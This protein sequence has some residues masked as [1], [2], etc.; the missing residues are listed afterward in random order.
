MAATL[1]YFGLNAAIASSSL[2]SNSSKTISQLFKPLYFFNSV[3]AASLLSDSS[4][5]KSLFKYCFWYLSDAGAGADVEVRVGVE[6]GAGAGTAAVEE[7][8]VNN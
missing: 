1:L 3:N 7:K 5:S 6:T 8:N 4:K 2:F